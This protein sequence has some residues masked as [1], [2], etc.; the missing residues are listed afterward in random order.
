MWWREFVWCLR[1][2]A[3]V[4]TKAADKRHWGTL[5]SKEN[6][7]EAE[8]VHPG[9]MT[10]WFKIAGCR[11]S[12][13]PSYH[14]PPWP[15]F[16]HFCLYVERTGECGDTASEL[17]TSQCLRWGVVPFHPVGRYMWPQRPLATSGIEIS[18][19]GLW[20]QSM[21]RDC[22]G[23]GRKDC[24]YPHPSFHWRWDGAH[25]GSPQPLLWFHLKE[26]GMR[27]VSCWPSR[28]LP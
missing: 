4:Q 26:H 13:P 18:V 3:K 14:T 23:P 9:N 11:T 27:R 19:R 25:R 16:L 2:L 21:R 28:L 24:S 1:I 10:M 20:R 5:H 15:L 6:C 22:R 12:L 17:Q 8:P 7:P